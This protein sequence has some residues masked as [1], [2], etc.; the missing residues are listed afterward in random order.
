MERVALSQLI[1]LIKTT[2]G[3]GSSREC[4]EKNAYIDALASPEYEIIPLIAL[5]RS[6]QA[7]EW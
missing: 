6:A 1:L 3:F 4:C 2:T 7:R 5:L